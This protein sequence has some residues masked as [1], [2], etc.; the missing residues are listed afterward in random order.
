MLD[1]IRRAV[2]LQATSNTERQDLERFLDIPS[3]TLVAESRPPSYTE[4]PTQGPNRFLPLLP[5]QDGRS[6]SGSSI[7]RSSTQGAN[8]TGS[9]GLSNRGQASTTGSTQAS[10]SPSARREQSSTTPTRS[11]RTS[12]SASTQRDQLQANYGVGPGQ[13]GAE[14]DIHDLLV[15]DPL[16]DNGASRNRSNDGQ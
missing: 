7:G 10:P 11:P 6:D 4:T 9:F 16:R 1:I 2:Q 3:P 8:Q 5:L 14:G 12:S 13:P 15:P